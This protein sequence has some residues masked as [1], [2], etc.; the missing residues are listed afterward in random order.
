MDW[1][2]TRRLGNSTSPNSKKAP[3]R[4]AKTSANYPYWWSQY[5]VVGDQSE[6]RAA[7][8]LWRFGP[9]AFKEYYNVRDP[10]TIQQRADAEVPLDK[11]YEEWPVGTDPN[12]HLK[13]ITELFQS[14][15][16]IVNIHSGQA[17]QKKVIHF[18]GKEVLPRLRS[19]LLQ[20]NVGEKA[21]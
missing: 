5:V 2:P 18:Y 21:A 7:A 9:K 4:Q 15:A 8:E 11:V 13:T 20:R 19:T 16:T 12:M 6:A 10:Q 1:S 14:G 17:D 3:K